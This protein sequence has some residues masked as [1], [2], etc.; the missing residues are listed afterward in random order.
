MKVTILG[1]SITSAWGNGH[2]TNYRALARALDR[3]GD[4]VT[5]LERDVPWYAQHRDLPDP[6]WCP[7]RMYESVIQ[8]ERSFAGPVREADL[9]VIGSFVPDGV[10]VASWVLDH[11]QGAVAFYD[12]DTPVTIGKLRRRDAE[13]LSPELVGRFDLYLSFTAG[14]ALE[15]LHEEFGARRPEAFYCFVDPGSYA[16]VGVPVEY[17]LNY[18]GTYSAG[19]QPAVDELLVGPA[20]ERPSEQFAV[21]GPMYPPDIDWPANLERIEHLAPADHPGFYSATRFT[22]NVTR[23]EMRALG[24]SPSVRLFEAGACG[25]AIISDPWA[26]IDTV[27]LPGEEI[28]VADSREDV[29]RL[30]DETSEEERARIGAAARRRVLAEHTAD[31]RVDQLHDFVSG[32]VAR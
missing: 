2:A 4:Q 17:A 21:A 9:V 19:R 1:L 16:P 31:R 10:E 25:A 18:L 5:F 8:L 14:P 32:G 30:L 23:P 13:Y 7:T 15:V 24:Y 3:R 12:I 29:L 28:L 26:G 27:F 22:L 11:A 20:R 6:P